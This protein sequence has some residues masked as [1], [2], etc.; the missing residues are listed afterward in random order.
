[1]YYNF[2]FM[3]AILK[4]NIKGYLIDILIEKGYNISY[5]ETYKKSENNTLNKTEIL[6]KK[7]KE[8]IVSLLYLDKDNL[9]NFE[10]SLVSDD[11]VLEKHFNL[12]LLLKNKIDDKLVESITE[13]LFIETIKCKYTKIKICKEIMSLLEINNLQLLNKELTKKFKNIMD[14]EWLKENIEIIKKIFEI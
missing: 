14:N 10:K 2:R 1:M 11:K 12:R 3:D 7:I 13:N 8:K 5:N 6:Q 9:S 4:T